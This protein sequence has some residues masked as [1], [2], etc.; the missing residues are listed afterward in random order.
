MRGRGG[1][2]TPSHASSESHDAQP[3]V[4]LLVE[5]YLSTTAWFVLRA[6]RRVEDH[7][8]SQR[9]SQRLK[10]TCVR[11]V[12]AI[13]N[14]STIM[15]I[16]CIVS[17]I[18]IDIIIIIIIMTIIS[19]SGSSGSSSSS[20]SSSS[21]RQISKISIGIISSVRQVVP[22]DSRRGGPR[23]RPRRR[24]P[25]SGRPFWSRLGTGARPCRSR[26]S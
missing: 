7:H 21:S 23:R 2:R 18:I 10:N 5:R 17:M 25:G 19:S 12:V 20:S 11:Q 15:T 26:A 1:P 6:L 9:Y 14:V 3:W 22:P 16:M 4:A 8:N 13:D 24:P